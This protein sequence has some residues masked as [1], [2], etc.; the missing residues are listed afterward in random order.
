LAAW[1]PAGNGLSTEREVGNER[2]TKFPPYGD[3]DYAS[4]PYLRSAVMAVD[5]ASTITRGF[6]FADLRGYTDFVEPPRRRR[7]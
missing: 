5:Q 2:D 1:R 3:A 4:Y 6:L 7:F